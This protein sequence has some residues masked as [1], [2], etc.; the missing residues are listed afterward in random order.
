[1]SDLTPM[2]QQMADR[3]DATEMLMP[4]EVRRAGERRRKRLVVTTATCA[5]LAIVAAGLLIR[6]VTRDAVSI[7]PTGQ[8]TRT[9][10]SS[11]DDRVGFVGPPPPGTSP[12]GP[13]TGELAAA[14]YLYNSGT[15]V[16]A[17]G[18]IINVV[19]NFETTDQF[20]G[21][22]VRQ[23]TPSGVEAMRSFLLD[24]TSGL[25]RV[26]KSGG[27]LIVRYGGRLM[28][29]RDFKG[30][31]AGHVRAGWANAVGCPDFTNPEGWLPADAWEDPTFRP[32]IPHA[33][34]LCLSRMDLTV[35]P[36]TA[37]DIFLASPVRDGLDAGDC[38]AVAT[39]DARTL[40]DTLE[41]AGAVSNADEHNLE[42]D[43]R[44]LG[45]HGFVIS[46]ILP[47]GRQ[48]YCNCG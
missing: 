18:R 35:L 30:C 4:H 42:V 22:V 15:W 39:S 1:M 24:G 27:E 12:T 46:P 29:A 9:T 11:P 40:V 43:L 17:D 14:A 45:G 37:A 23:L 2:L 20:R 5:V 26:D 48:I 34:E 13:A 25:T 16:Y 3:A 7:Y 10:S 6:G 44:D 8:P 31:T 36:A 32:F 28:F 19:R 47:D 33:Y 41:D 38:R 21:Y